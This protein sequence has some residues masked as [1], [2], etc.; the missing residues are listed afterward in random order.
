MLIQTLIYNLISNSI[1]HN[2]PEGSLNF[3]LTT[4]YLK[5]ENSG[6]PLSEDAELMFERFRKNSDSESSVGL[7]LS[8]VKK[9]CDL[10]NFK[11]DYS[12]KGSIH[13]TILNFSLAS[14]EV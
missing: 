6:K 2:I 3:E 9:I 10:F 11:V 5:I 14:A 1:K 7:G 8:I 4:N 13:T 12:N